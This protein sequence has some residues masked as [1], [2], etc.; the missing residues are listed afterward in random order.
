V[1]YLLHDADPDIY[2]DPNNGDRDSSGK[3][4]ENQKDKDNNPKEKEKEKKEEKRLEFQRGSQKIKSL[5]TPSLFVEQFR[6]LV[7]PDAPL[8]EKLALWFDLVDPSLRSKYQD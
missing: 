5:I 7:D 1:D 8:K 3:N 6:S 2:Y 4:D